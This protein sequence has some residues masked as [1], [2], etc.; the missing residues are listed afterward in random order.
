M[1]EEQSH[2]ALITGAAS[3]IG[4][5]AALALAA[6]G[7]KVAVA[8]LNFAGA[9]ACV[10]EIVQAGGQALA[11][12][13][14]VCDGASVERA[15]AQTE[16]ALGAVDILVNSAGIVGIF[17]LPEYPMEN[18]ERVLAVNVTGTFRCA[19]RAAIGMM[20]RGYGRIINLASVGGVRAG[21]GRTAYG[22]S[23]AAVIGL[24][25]Q[26]AMELA[27]RGV[28]ANAVAP[29][30]VLTNLT[31]DIYTPQTI[32]VLEAMVPTGRLGTPEEIVAAIVFLASR[33]ASYVNGHT[34]AVDGGFLAAGVT[35]TANLS[36]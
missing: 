6:R 17:P 25:R 26:L 5:A 7:D 18:W 35:R 11:L 15:F 9:Q 28:T 33:E 19:Q 3:G 10:Q 2:V 21:I 24:T 34:L 32:E 23:K 27:P 8:D 30:P 14:D 13:L 12:Q 16:A 20:A 36:R 22:T 31:V 1:K 4:R 29:G